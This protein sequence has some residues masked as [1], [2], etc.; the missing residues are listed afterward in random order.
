MPSVPPIIPRLGHHRTILI[1]WGHS[2]CPSNRHLQNQG[3]S[4]GRAM[5]PTIRIRPAPT[6]WWSHL[7]G[8][9]IHQALKDLSTLCLC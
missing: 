1:K 4:K 5:L 3:P 6:T 9:T 7:D 8:A 2:G